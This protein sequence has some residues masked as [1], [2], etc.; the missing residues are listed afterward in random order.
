VAVCIVTFD[1]TS[2]PN[3]FFDSKIVREDLLQIALR[4]SGVSLL[5]FAK[6]ALFRAEH[7]S[8]AIHVNA[9]ALQNHVVRLAIAFN[10]GRKLLEF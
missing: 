5:D 7:Q 4:E 8:L 3:Y 6:Q 2:E 10:Y 1:A 9:A